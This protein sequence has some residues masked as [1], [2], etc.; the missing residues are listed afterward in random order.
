MTCPSQYF[1]S[2]TEYEI[3]RGIPS[4]QECEKHCVGLLRTIT[5]LEEK[6]AHTTTF[7]YLALLDLILIG[8][9]VTS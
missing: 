9:S 4:A 2:V 1:I 3:A 5:G 6:E 8:H 7:L